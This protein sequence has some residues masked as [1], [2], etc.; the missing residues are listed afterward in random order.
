MS[1]S[2]TLAPPFWATMCSQSFAMFAAFTTIMSLSSKPVDDAVV[3]EVPCSRQERGVLRLARLQR[4]DVVAGDLLTNALRSGPVT[5]NSPMC[6]TSNIPTPSRTARCSAMIPVGILHRHLEP[7]ERDHLGA[8]T[9]VHC[10]E[11]RALEVFGRQ[12][13]LASGSAHQR[14][15]QCLLN[16]Q[17]VLGFVPHARL[18]SV[19]HVRGDFFAAVRRQAMQEDRAGVGASISCA[20][21]V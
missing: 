14:G 2:R 5:S 3:D 17:P 15:N 18:R 21:T 6:D 20:S 8:Q 9:G 13:S 19:D 11:R 12:C 16:V 10:V 7:G 4:A 1:R